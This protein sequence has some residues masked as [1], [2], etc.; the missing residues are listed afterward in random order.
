MNSLWDRLL[1]LRMLEGDGGS[2]GGSGDGDNNPPAGGDPNTDTRFTQE[3]VNG[4]IASE[5]RKNNA[6]L[7]KDLGFENLED[8]KNAIAE[9]NAAK[10]KQKDDTTKAQEKAEQLQRE[11]DAELAK[12]TKL[13]NKLT[14][15]NKGCDPK[16]ADD[17]V[18]LAMAKVTDDVDFE[19][20][21]EE[22]KKLY[23]AMFESS[24]NNGGTGHGGNPPR[25]RMTSGDTEGIG[26]R[27][28]EQRKKDNSTKKNSYFND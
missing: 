27:L 12:A 7:L 14:A 11:K 2:G 25:G 8:A 3:Q 9:Y 24:N 1:N 18:T 26:K 22:V 23:P 6:A 20:A 16:N 21:L 17:V 15:I 28:A 10:E 13:E 19:A 4:I 5:K